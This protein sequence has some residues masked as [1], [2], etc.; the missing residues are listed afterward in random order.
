MA[1]GVAGLILLATLALGALLLEPSA[2][3]LWVS[4]PWLLG[5]GGGLRVVHYQEALA[6]RR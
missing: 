3:W 4:P 2:W 1:A 5:L 6:H